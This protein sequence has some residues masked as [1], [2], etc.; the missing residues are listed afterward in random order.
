MQKIVNLLRGS[1]RL[2]V[3]GA[4]PE[5]FLNLC[6]QNR[7]AFWGVTLVSPHQLELMVA[8]Q[9]ARRAQGLGQGA[10]CAVTLA[11]NRGLPAFL[12]RFRRRYGFL[13]GLMLSL[14]AVCVL[15]QFVL[16]IEVSGNENL[17]TAQILSDLRLVGVRPGAYGPGIDL[18]MAGQ[19]MLQQNG[20][21]A[22][23]AINLRGTVAQV[24]VRERLP[25]PKPANT[26]QTG[27][28]R[29]QA[30]GIITHMEVLE[31]EPTCKVG[32][33]VLAGDIL[34][35][36]NIH[37]EPPPYS[38][39]DLGWRQVRAQGRVYAR[40]WRT[41]RG[42]L[43]LQAT[44][45]TYTGAEQQRF[46]AEILGIRVNFYRNAGISFA[47]YDKIEQVYSV[48]TSG[49]RQLPF[50]LRRE[51]LREYTPASAEIDRDGGIEMLSC[52]LAKALQVQLEGGEQVSATYSAQERDGVLTVTLRAECK[53]EIGKFVA[54]GE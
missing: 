48:P 4:Y 52:Q 33:V 42:S 43:P 34:I 31:G 14:L 30:G 45:K 19:R 38:N 10:D 32:D 36:G 35:T 41:L 15:S 46:S 24:L 25:H 5:Q 7:L 18:A 16:N 54:A 53:E 51:I 29:A 37:M 2:S 50:F 8:R 40:T 1:V 22:W 44:T 23:C 21:L 28:V 12:L 47:K 39:I 20:D 17:S 13:A 26:G 6:A 9:H 49:G 11:E 3:E 27:D